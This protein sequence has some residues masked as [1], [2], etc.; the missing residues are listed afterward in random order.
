MILPRL[1]RAF[2][3]AL[4]LSL[5]AG[6]AEPVRK[7][8]ATTDPMQT[9]A[10]RS[11]ASPGAPHPGR[12]GPLTADERAIAAAA[13]RYIVNNTQPQTGLVNAVDD[14]PSTTMWDTAS[15]MA[16]IVSAQR[17]GLIDPEAAIARLKPMLETLRDISLFRDLCPNKA[18]NTVTAE[19]VNYANA[20]GEIGCSALDVGRLL[21]WLRI[22][23]QQ[24]PSLAPAVTAV[25]D[26]LNV[27]AMVSD[28]V[29]SG[30]AIDADGKTVML[31]EGRLGYEEYAARGFSMWG[32][33]T[34]V[35]ARAEPYGLVTLYGVTIHYDARDPRLLGAHN[36]VVAEG[37]ILDGVEFGW[38][39]PADTT[40]DPFAHKIGWRARMA[41]QIY[42]AQEARHARTGIL[43]ARTEHQ[44]S[45]PPYFV[46]DTL[47]SD[48]Q[49]WAT[50]TDTGQS[51]PA[52][53]ALASK[54]A[55]G[56]WA[57]WNTPYTDRLLAAV[58]ALVATDRGVAEGLL[59]QGGL[60]IATYTV[61]TNGII[62]ESLAYKQV[63][64]LHAAALPLPRPV[65]ARATAMPVLPPP[66]PSSGNA[67]DSL[68]GPPRNGPLTPAELEA[69]RVAWRYFANNTQ[70]RSGL[71]NAVDN[72][73]STTLWDTAAALGAIVAADELDIIAGS[74]AQDRLG[75]IITTF[76]SI[77]LF[78]EK[79][80]NKAYN[81]ISL[82][83]TDYG[84]NPGEIGCSALD[85]GR[86]LVWMRIVHNRYPALRQ[87]VEAAVTYWQIDNLVREGELFGTVLVGGRI[88]YRQEGRLGYEEY[89]AK[90]FQLWG[91]RTRAASRPEPFAIANIEGMEIAHDR[92][93][94]ANS[95]GSNYVVTE[96]Y[97]LD[98]IE[99]GWMTPGRARPDPFTVEQGRN[100][101]LAQQRRYRRTGILTA[102]TEHQLLTA[103]HFVYDTVFANGVPWATVDFN[104]DRAE[105]AAAVA[106]KAAIGMWALWP[107]NYSD[108]L[109]QTVIDSRDPD[110]G[111]H[112]G[113]LEGGGPIRAFTANNNGIIL[114]TLL[115]KA[116]GA[117]IQLPAL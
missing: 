110:R 53:A 59:E 102:R 47:Y 79:C 105:G 78:Q 29:L 87:K 36:Y 111:F 64:K 99:F 24:Y 108:L 106:S 114:E 83:P 49:P 62:L 34:S 35:A 48:G 6:A 84:N 112:E 107:N 17:I 63:G 65:F 46:Y 75:R 42:R 89:A 98:G 52:A 26:H 74:E 56:L 22:V 54:A 9:G 2:A 1:W 92:R 7:A 32:F 25:A 85:I 10:W 94:A 70:P 101:F 115:F 103:P 33:D 45:G 88:E 100:L 37:A 81:T 14:Y 18:Y 15:A 91:Q 28:G 58:K 90:G 3:V 60:P 4:A 104:G 43:T 44:L 12:F 86:M 82:V 39:D 113:I 19:P 95:G 8:A 68:P 77:R 72:Y 109:F 30:A 93:D 51:V 57:L 50:I 66:H 5:P 40:T 96:S 16:G 117:L 116:K 27:G 23:T 73:P 69:A 11:S 61:N 67:T 20:P 97:A 13:W 76:G 31:Q 80:P 41:D 71:V 38:N 55:V 21:I